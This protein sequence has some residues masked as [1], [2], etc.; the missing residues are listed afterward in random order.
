MKQVIVFIAIVGV[1]L[2]M[3]P[4][5]EHIRDTVDWVEGKIIVKG[6]SR[7]EA[8]AEDP[9]SGK[10][11]LTRTRM[12]AS[13]RARED[14]IARLARLV[15]TIRVDS[16]SMLSDILERDEEA[17]R[18]LAALI[19]S[20]TSFREYPTG[21]LSS[22]CRAEFK[23]GDLIH[24]LPFSYPMDPFPARM[25]NPIPTA[26]TGLVI[27]ARGIGVEPMILPSIYREDGVEIYGRTFVDIRRAGKWGI[28]SY[29]FNEDEAMRL[30]RAGAR[31]YYC[32]A[33]RGMY[34]CPVLADRDARKIF[35]S[36]ET[37]QKLR[38]CRVVFI[39]DKL[40]D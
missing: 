36:N 40:K 35:S 24:I 15:K 29:A 2:A 12:E 30:G 21:F 31:P 6:A 14:S 10:T 19:S 39:I 17:Q 20:R 38:E 8:A 28:A 34:G 13:R 23:I 3:R 27:D 32:V 25:D 16:D 9:E 5:R 33:I 26:Y 22:A 37:I 11:S 7:L 18:R 1:S 4:Q